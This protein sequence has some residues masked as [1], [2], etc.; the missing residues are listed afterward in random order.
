I[1]IVAARTGCISGHDRSDQR[2][3]PDDVHDPCQIVGQDRER[4]FGGDF[5]KRSGEEVRRP[6]AGLHGTEGMLD[7]LATLA[8]RFWVCVKA[9]LHSLE[10]MLMLPPCNSPLWPGCALRFE[11][12][13]LTRCGPVAPQHL[14]VFFG[15]I[16]IRQSL[17]G[18]TAIGV[19]LWQIDEV[20]LTEAPVRFGARR[21]RL[22][23]SYGNACFVAG[24]DFWAV[25]VAA[26]SYGFERLG[27]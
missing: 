3:D 8:H 11:R 19:L 22:G 10:Q 2:L 24:E 5:R 14:A 13:I 23:Q 17:P 25:E 15:C 20:L 18:R 4:H 9:L 6:H 12:T 1:S 27:L 26:I 21:V 16:A 7:C